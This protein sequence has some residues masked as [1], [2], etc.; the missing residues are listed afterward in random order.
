MIDWLTDDVIADG[1]GRDSSQ[2]SELYGR[3]TVDH[4]QL[5]GL[6]VITELRCSDIVSSCDYVKCTSV[7]QR[8]VSQRVHD[9]CHLYTSQQRHTCHMTTLRSGSL[10][11]VAI[12]SVVCLSV[13]N[14]R[15]PYA[16]RWSFRQYFFIA[17][18]AGHPLTPVQNFTEIVLG[19]PLQRQS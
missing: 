8:L 13:C 7:T 10:L 12:P 11:A 3:Q 17:L 14:V 15:A 2:C 19:E 9:N 6:T 4:R 18:Y 1:R 16:Q 5:V